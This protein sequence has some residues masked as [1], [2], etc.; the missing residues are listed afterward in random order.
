MHRNIP[1][2]FLHRSS[3]KT[4]TTEQDDVPEAPCDAAAPTSAKFHANLDKIANDTPAAAP[5][6]PVVKR[7]ATISNGSDFPSKFCDQKREQLELAFN[8][9]TPASRSPSPP[10][11]I[12]EG[13]DNFQAPKDTILRAL[14]APH[15]IQSP[16][17]LCPTQPEA[18]NSRFFE[19]LEYIRQA[20]ERE[21]FRQQAWQ[22]QPFYHQDPAA[23]SYTE[24]Y[25]HLQWCGVQQF[26][27]PMTLPTPLHA[28]VVPELS[29]GMRFFPHYQ[30]LVSEWAFAPAQSY[31]PDVAP[32]ARVSYIELAK[33]KDGSQQLQL[34]LPSLPADQL[35]EV[36][37]ALTPK[38]FE[39]TTH[40]FGNYLVSALVERTTS[41][42]RHLAIAIKGRVAK[43]MQHTQG[44]RVVQCAL[45]HLPTSKARALVGELRGK[46][47]Q[48]ARDK[49][50]KY[51]ILIALKCTREPWIVKE[52]AASL[53]TLSTSRNGS[54]F[55]QRLL[56]PKRELLPQPLHGPGSYGSDGL[57]GLHHT[58]DVRPVLDTL[59][60]MSSDEL[61][62]L[63][64]DEYANFV[65]KL[66]LLLATHREALV[67]AL[68]PKLEALSVTKW[69]S[70]VA[71]AVVHVASPLQLEQARAAL[72]AVP[73]LRGH[74]FASF[75][76]VAL[77][78]ACTNKSAA[79]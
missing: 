47:A 43:L 68:L 78:R 3:D 41:I 15:A 74:A 39:L 14:D 27:H 26:Q 46:V 57:E 21:F 75:V 62:A 37:R 77:E 12:P 11:V 10:T 6:L 35:D 31:M 36:V 58:C 1:L 30:S 9:S 28:Q 61:A 2:R 54:L 48:V 8:L 71:K 5:A 13:V 72:T 44:C 19:D 69:G 79:E 76:I 53:S 40:K 66:G 17:T 65:V 18:A 63:A 59:V 56:D 16:T 7:S 73:S 51:S 49:E 42:H 55:L 25:R 50:G 67:G 33:D 60:R 45:E 22:D 23:M 24:P 20:T 38:L 52:V 70:H 34:Q 32:Q 4:G 29:A 64:T